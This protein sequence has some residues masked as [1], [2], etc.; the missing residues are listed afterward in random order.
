MLDRVFFKSCFAKIA[1]SSSA[2]LI[3]FRE[4]GNRAS[5]TGMLAHSNCKNWLFANR[6][7][8]LLE[9]IILRTVDLRNAPFRINCRELSALLWSNAF[10]EYLFSDAGKVDRERQPSECRFRPVVGPLWR[11]PGWDKLPLQPIQT[12]TGLPVLISI[13]SRKLSQNFEVSRLARAFPTCHWLKSLF[14]P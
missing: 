12:H 1:P 4:M 8:E 2:F 10:T 6:N 9:A 13:A 5:A 14:F 7:A 3:V 11:V